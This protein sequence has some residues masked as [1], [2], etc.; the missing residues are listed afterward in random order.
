MG[1]NSAINEN[2]SLTK[3]SAFITFDRIIKSL[4]GTVSGIKMVYLDSP[5]TYIAK[6]V[7]FWE[8]G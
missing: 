6:K 1:S 2:I 4:D 8:E 5:T 7:G 3:G